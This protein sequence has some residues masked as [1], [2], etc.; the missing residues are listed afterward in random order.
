MS[1]PVGGWRDQ[2]GKQITFDQMIDMLSEAILANLIAM[3]YVGIRRSDIQQIIG[4][5]DGTLIGGRA[6]FQ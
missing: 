1:Q 4:R 5:D 6:M 3:D 2:Q